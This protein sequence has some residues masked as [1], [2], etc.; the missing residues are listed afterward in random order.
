MV[1]VKKDPKFENILVI[2]AIFTTNPEPGQAD[3]I[4]FWRILFTY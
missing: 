4:I 1:T 2:F 3:D